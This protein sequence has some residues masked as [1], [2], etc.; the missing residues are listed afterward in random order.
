MDYL[1]KTL[2]HRGRIYHQSGG[3][4]KSRANS[5]LLKYAPQALNTLI[6]RDSHNILIPDS[7]Y[8]H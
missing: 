1:I 5:S 2:P 3:Q 7:L 8:I 4:R 6:V